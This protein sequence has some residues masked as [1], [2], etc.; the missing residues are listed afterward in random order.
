MTINKI[1]GDINQ[2]NE[3]SESQMSSPNDVMFLSSD[4][5]FKSAQ[6]LKHL[7]VCMPEYDG[8]ISETEVELNM[9]ITSPTESLISSTYSVYTA[10]T[11]NTNIL[12]QNYLSP[13][14]NTTTSSMM[15]YKIN[16]LFMMSK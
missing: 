1:N 10:H 9:E 3:G 6:H 14:T 16:P 11:N 2:K 7:K 4:M 13:I 12:K 5:N 15:K 8:N